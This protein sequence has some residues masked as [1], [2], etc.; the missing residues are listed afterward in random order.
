MLNVI[1]HCH[2]FLWDFSIPYARFFGEQ[3]QRTFRDPHSRD[4]AAAQSCKYR[5]TVHF[6]TYPLCRQ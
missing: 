5:F 6:V 4:E 1:Q 2:E 3:G